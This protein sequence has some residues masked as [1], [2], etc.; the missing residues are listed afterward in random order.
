MLII[1][2]KRLSLIATTRL[3]QLG[4]VVPFY[5]N[6]TAYP[7]ISGHPDVFICAMPHTTIVAPNTPQYLLNKLQ[8]HSIYFE[9]GQ[10]E[11]GQSYPDTARYNAVV[12]K[13]Y[14]I[15]NTAISDKTLLH[16]SS[17][18]KIINIKQG[19]TRCS[20]LAIGEESFI[21]SDKGIYKSIKNKVDILLV[22]DSNISLP[23][24]KHGFFGGIAGIH[25]KTVFFSGDIDHLSDKKIIISFLTER[26]YKTEMLSEGAPSDVGGIFF[27]E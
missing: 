6:N 5:S 18:K 20:L 3:Q 4:E 10:Q 2:D 16:H 17:S 24:F 27:L 14:F 9:K 19:Y 8:Q 21:T 23:D 12:T 22:D 13:K 11:V 26:G 25:K 1:V 15:H 7:A